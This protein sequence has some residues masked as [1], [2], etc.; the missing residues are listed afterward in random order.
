VDALTASPVAHTIVR[1]T[2]FFSDMRAFLDM[3]ARGRVYLVGDGRHRIN[4]ISGRNLAVACVQAAESGSHE[5]E[6]GGPETFSDQ[7]I[8]RLA[9]QVVDRPI[10][11]TRLPPG[12]LRV[13]A[14]SR[15]GPLQ[16]FL[17]VMTHDLVAPSSGTDFLGDF[18]R[19]AYGRTNTSMR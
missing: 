8:A 5:I 3:A 14:P 19:Q 1:P 15:Y 6:V 16:F 7:Q 10:R 12:P 4:P 17:A 9:A 13:I 11:I 2:G 18:F